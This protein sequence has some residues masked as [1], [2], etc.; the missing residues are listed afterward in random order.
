MG[1]NANFERYE[2]LN[3]DEIE[4]ILSSLTWYASD[5]EGKQHAGRLTWTREKVLRAKMYGHHLIPLATD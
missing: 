2:L 1:K 3:P 5:T 4:L